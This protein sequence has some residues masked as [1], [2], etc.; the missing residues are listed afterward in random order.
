[1]VNNII[2]L[3]D[4]SILE[5][6]GTDNKKFL[7]GLI[8][9]DIYKATNYNLIYSAMLSST[10]RFLYDFFIFE[11]EDKI[12]LD[13]LLSR[14]D[15]ILQ[16]LNFYKLR[17]KVEIVKN[18]EFLIA[19]SLENDSCN[20]ATKLCFADPR[21]KNLFNRI[22]LKKSD[23]NQFNFAEELNYHYLR[24]KNKVAEGEYDL[25]QDKSFILEF[26]FDN[27]NAIDYQKGC[28]IGQELTARTHYRGEIRK[29]LFHI[30]IAN[31]EHVGKNSEITCEGNS[32]GI[33]LSSVFFNNETHALALIKISDDANVENSRD[34]LENLEFEK[35]KITIIS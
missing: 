11:I 8:T 9:N 28:Y 30:K 32:M 27:L 33:V 20:T 16:K 10:G 17:S 34:Q 19:Q 18:D 3:E 31:I 7:Q 22:Y 14:R 6:K 24:I 26:D 15:E 13:C 29:K 25:T 21:N 2:I 4:R 1:M 5:I 35:N 23:A 12:M